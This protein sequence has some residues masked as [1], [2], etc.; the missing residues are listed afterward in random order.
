MDLQ[1]LN[2]LSE[3]RAI[4]VFMTCCGSARWARGM[5]ARR[6]FHSRGELLRAADLEF[7]PFDRSDWLEAFAAH[8]R[9]GERPASTTDASALSMAEQSRVTEASRA[10]FEERNR[11]YEARFGYT[12]IVRA[13]GRTGE[14]MLT[15]LERRML[16]TPQDELEHA[17]QEQRQ[18]TQRRIAAALLD[19][20]PS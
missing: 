6:P 7:D 14:E 11:A 19:G 9:I 3:A 13:A 12:F 18:I 17:A 15:I 20:Q 1:E 10:M 16:N 4:E 2:A 8:P 5:S